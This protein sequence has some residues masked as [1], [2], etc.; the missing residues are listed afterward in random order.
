MRSKGT[1]PSVPL[2]K[3]KRNVSLKSF[4]EGDEL[5]KW[6]K[7]VLTNVEFS[8]LLPVLS[9]CLSMEQIDELISVKG[10]EEVNAEEEEDVAE[11][12]TKE[13]T[14]PIFP[15]VSLGKDP[16]ENSDEDEAKNL[17]MNWPSLNDEIRQEVL[18]N[19]FRGKAD[20][21]VGQDNYWSLVLEGV[22]KHPSEKFGI[23]NTKLGWTMG[24]SICT[25]L[26][27]KWQ[28]GSAVK[29]D[30]YYN[31]SNPLQDMT[32]EE[33]KTSLIKLFEKESDET[34][35]STYTVEEQ[36]AIDSFAK[37]IKREKDGRYTVCPLFKKESVPIKNNYYLAKRRYNSLKQ[38]LMKQEEIKTKMYSE[39]LQK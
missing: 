36:F 32:E 29:L 23:I 1:S 34:A 15:E 7:L 35:N 26:P 10:A 33:I 21:L 11:D 16:K 12:D 8:R 25:T 9:S 24:G 2:P 3:I 17:A 4:L 37:N 13:E 38:T 20:I 31:Q 19:R 6:L 27:E 28:Q 14:M 30:V 22:I 39:A 18:E 5:I